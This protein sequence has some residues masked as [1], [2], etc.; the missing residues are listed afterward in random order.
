MIKIHL[1]TVNL[2]EQAIKYIYIG[3]IYI[4][5]TFLKY[6]ILYKIH[7]YDTQNIVKF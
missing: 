6:S 5:G 1:N 3:E 4:Y 7:N 2:Y